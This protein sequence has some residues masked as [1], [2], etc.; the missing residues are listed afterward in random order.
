[1]YDRCEYN[2]AVIKMFLAIFFCLSKFRILNSNLADSLH[3]LNA[4]SLT[5]VT[6]YSPSYDMKFLS[7]MF[8]IKF[9]FF[10]IDKTS[11]EN[12]A[13]KTSSVS[14]HVENLVSAF[15]KIT[16]TGLTVQ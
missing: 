13:V 9:L 16:L 2:N 14:L 3:L 5:V 10:F 15:Q 6:K 7:N 4:H 11:S 1:M 12:I 8:S